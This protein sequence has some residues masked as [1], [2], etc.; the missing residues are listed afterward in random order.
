MWYGYNLCYMMFIDMFIDIDIGIS[1]AV[2][3]LHIDSWL[4][5][6]GCYYTAVDEFAS[7]QLWSRDD[8]AGIECDWVNSRNILY[9]VPIDYVD[10]EPIP[11]WL[12]VWV[13]S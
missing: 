9:A 10:D 6:D 13:L 8:I 11:N 2:Y 4:R 12:N 7:A 3:M 5:H 1:Y